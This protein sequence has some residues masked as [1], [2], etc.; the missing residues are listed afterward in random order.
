MAATK[1]TGDSTIVV[2]GNSPLPL[3]T[4]SG[5]DSTYIFDG[6]VYSFILPGGEKIITWIGFSGNAF[7]G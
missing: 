3:Q 6:N 2:D 7:I 1:T 4:F 5:N